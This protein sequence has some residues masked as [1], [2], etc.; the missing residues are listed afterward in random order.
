MP[1]RR[2]W[3]MTDRPIISTRRRREHHPIL[4]VVAD[5]K[6][7]RKCR[8]PE[9]KNNRRA[10]RPCSGWHGRVR[11]TVYEE[12]TNLLRPW[13]S[14]FQAAG[15][16]V[17]VD[18]QCLADSSRSHCGSTGHAR[19]RLRTCP[20]FPRSFPRLSIPHPWRRPCWACHPQA[21]VGCWHNQIRI[22]HH[23][24]PSGIG[25]R[26]T[27]S[28]PR[29]AWRHRRQGLWTASRPCR[30]MSQPSHATTAARHA[31]QYHRHNR[32]AC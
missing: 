20:D 22:G 24:R 5:E 1:S 14:P 3:S 7:V 16:F 10:T 2:R 19:R 21:L 11:A 6:A 28:H 15:V 27:R 9:Q 4:V 31:G 32:Q 17:C 18:P 25:C 30:P 13:N 23:R 26:K 12:V 29:T 8:L